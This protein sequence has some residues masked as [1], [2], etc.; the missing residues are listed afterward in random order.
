MRYSLEMTV[1]R[2]QDPSTPVVWLDPTLPRELWD[3][4]PAA[5]ESAGYR[6][7]PLDPDRPLFSTRDLTDRLAE[8]AGAGT[9]HAE[10]PELFQ[11][12]LQGLS[13]PNP[14]GLVLVWRQPQFYRNENEGGFEE[15]VDVV[16]ALHESPHAQTGIPPKLILAD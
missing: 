1:A 5:L 10:S 12:L 16:E 9:S 15:F 3:E 2:V 4:L 6:V 8:L 7:T 13:S 11:T 14:P